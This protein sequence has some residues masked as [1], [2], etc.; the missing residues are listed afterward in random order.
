MSAEVVPLDAAVANPLAFGDFAQGVLKSISQVFLKAS[1]VAALLLLAG[2]AVNSLA[3]AAF[4]LGGAV[5][6]VWPHTCWARRATWS[7]AG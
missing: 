3:A 2:L 7:P 4:G 5:V 6:A 1:L